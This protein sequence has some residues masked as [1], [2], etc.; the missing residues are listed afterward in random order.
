MPEL[1]LG[2]HIRLPDSIGVF[3]C[4]FLCSSCA[5]FFEKRTFP[6]A[7]SFSDISIFN[8]CERRCISR[9]EEID[10]KRRTADDLPFFLMIRCAPYFLLSRNKQ[11]QRGVQ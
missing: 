8:A 2:I 9:Q 4:A 6:Y 5:L 1:A 11:T 7:S 10:A 3:R